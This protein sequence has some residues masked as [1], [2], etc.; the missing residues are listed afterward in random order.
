MHTSEASPSEWTVR[1]A[2]DLGRAVAGVRG[3]CGL[4]QQRLAE[5]A[6][7][8]RSY[9]ARLEAGGSTLAIERAVRLLRRMGATITVTLREDDGARR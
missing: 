1:S 4:T 7:V 3:R 9:L 8:E 2:A 5:E 6:G